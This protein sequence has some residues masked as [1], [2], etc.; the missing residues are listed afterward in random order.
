MQ[1][2]KYFLSIIFSIVLFSCSNDKTTVEKEKI[3]TVYV[4]G[5]QLI[6]NLE[7]ATI[8][9]NGVAQLLPT[10]NANFSRVNAI[11]VDQDVIYA[12]GYE[13]F[14]N[15][16]SGRGRATLWINNEKITLQTNDSEA[17]SISIYKGSIYIAGHSNLIATS[18]KVTNNIIEKTSLAQIGPSVAKSII[19]NDNGLFVAGQIS[20]YGWISSANFPLTFDQRSVAQSFFVQG[21]DEYVAVN[22][23]DSNLKN[24]A[25]ILKNGIVQ[26]ALVYNTEINSIYGN[27]TTIYAVGITT[28]LSGITKATIWEN[29]ISRPLSQKSSIATSVFCLNGIVY[30][31]GFEYDTNFDSYSARLWTQ[32]VL[33]ELSNNPS[34]ANAVFVTEQ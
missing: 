14:E 17:Y 18:W 1:I 3:T 28:T 10:E 19:K 15:A 23:L 11:Y 33:T 13:Y 26:N 31:C 4:G 24:T 12:V 8:W 20:L 32:G 5:I 2:L 34:F 6:N 9:R 16:V 29:N 27:K 7:R 30:T 25:K 22:F 21:N